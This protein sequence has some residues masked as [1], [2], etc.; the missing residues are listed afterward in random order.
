MENIQYKSSIPLKE[1]MIPIVTPKKPGD[2]VKDMSAVEPFAIMD[3]VF[4]VGR[5]DV[6]VIVVK[7]T[8]GIVLIDAMDP[9]NA[10]ERYIKPGLEKLGFGKEKVLACFITHEHGDHYLGAKELRERTGCKMIMSEV[11]AYNMTQPNRKGVID[12]Y[13]EVD[14]FAEDNSQFTFGEKTFYIART[15]G[16]SQG[17]ISI[18]FGAQWKGEKHTVCVWGGTGMP[19]EAYNCCPYLASAM[20]FAQFCKEHS[21]DVE[22]SAHPFVDDSISKG[23]HLKETGENLFIIGEEGVAQ[24]MYQRAATVMHELA[25]YVNDMI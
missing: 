9:E 25:K 2:K 10:D 21:A 22:I 5:N 6:G 19:F 13:P 12:L 15:P 20:Y 11:G 24:F 18:C 4:Y 17:C 16:H 8:D 7:T 3:D 23:K 14:L 1:E